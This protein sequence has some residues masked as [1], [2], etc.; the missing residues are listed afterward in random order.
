MAVPFKKCD[1]QV[2]LEFA[3]TSADRGL[4]LVEFLGSSREVPMPKRRLEWD[5]R[6]KGREE[7]IEVRHMICG[8]LTSKIVYLTGRL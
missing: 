2:G 3:D 1:S 4:R 8:Y 7:L 5:E 6:R